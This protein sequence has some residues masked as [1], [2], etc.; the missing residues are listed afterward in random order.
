MV[1]RRGSK[2]GVVTSRTLRKTEYFGKPRE[3]H[4]GQF[5]VTKYVEQG[6]GQHH[7]INKKFQEI[8][9]DGLEVYDHTPF[10][11]TGED[12]KQIISLKK[13]KITRKN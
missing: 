12:D 5:I 1:H 10:R 3:F 2:F 7:T 4:N 9:Q 13:D 8:L 11:N 6:R